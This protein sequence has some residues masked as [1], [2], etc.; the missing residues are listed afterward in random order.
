[1]KTKLLKIFRIKN[2]MLLI[3]VFPFILLLL[4]IPFSFY[5]I[6]TLG[7][8]ESHIENILIKAF[9]FI[10]YYIILFFTFQKIFNM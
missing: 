7:A 3:T 1:M 2:K 4:I 5:I 8:N 9:I 10:L 6:V